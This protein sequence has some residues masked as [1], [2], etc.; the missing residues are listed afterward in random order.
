MRGK[1]VWNPRLYIRLS[2]ASKRLKRL[3]IDRFR[4]SHIRYH[5]RKDQFLCGPVILPSSSTASSM[6]IT[7]TI[8]CLEQL[9]LYETAV[10]SNLLNENRI[11]SNRINFFFAS[12]AINEEDG[13]EALTSAI[14]N[15]LRIFPSTVV[16][17]HCGTAAPRGIASRFSARYR[18]KVVYKAIIKG[19]AAVVFE[20][21]WPRSMREEGE[22]DS[23]DNKRGEDEEEE[24]ISI[25]APQNRVQ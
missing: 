22:D 1:T 7:I 20:L 8:P 3:L 24:D 17:A 19:A 5:S 13:S 14:R 23:H 21:M 9:R 18:G 12:T 11:E 16:D 2:Q 15:I 4:G 6:A 25:I 10:E